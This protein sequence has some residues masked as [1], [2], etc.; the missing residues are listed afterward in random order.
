MI[1]KFYMLSDE[2]KKDI[3]NN[4]ANYTIEE[5]EEKLSVICFRKKINFDLEED[6][7]TSKTTEQP[8]VTFNL[9]NEEEAIPAWLKAVDNVK[10]NKI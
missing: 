1:G 7:D 3:I 9:S 10:N 6:N 8:V 5:I 2:D 4:K